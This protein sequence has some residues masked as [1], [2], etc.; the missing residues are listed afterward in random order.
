MPNIYHVFLGTHGKRV[1]CHVPEKLPTA[2][3][4][5]HGKYAVSRSACSIIAEPE[6]KAFSVNVYF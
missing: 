5:E 1:V 6:H 3:F 2:N 4:R